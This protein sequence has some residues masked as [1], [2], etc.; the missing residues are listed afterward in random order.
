MFDGR[1]GQELS[2]WSVVTGRGKKS[3][4]GAS[5]GRQ[6]A[7]CWRPERVWSRSPAVRGVGVSTPSGITTWRKWKSRKV[8]G[9]MW[10]CSKVVL[11][12]DAPES[13]AKH[14]HLL[15]R[16]PRARLFS[17]RTLQNEGDFLPLTGITVRW[18]RS[19]GETSL[20]SFSIVQSS[21][22]TRP[23]V[24]LRPGNPLDPT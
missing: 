4:L 1:S 7:R 22:G 5:L 20:V 14:S 21:G 17:E 9:G 16:E 19:R 23:H 24:I 13:P 11:V 12:F 3:P 8:F 18:R 2:I 6:P 15:E 10:N